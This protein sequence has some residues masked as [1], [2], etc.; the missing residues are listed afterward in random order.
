M[1][2][3][4]TQVLECPTLPSD[5]ATCHALIQ[6]QREQLDNT[7][8]KLSQMEHQLQQLLRRLYGRSAEKID[9]KQMA[10]FAEMLKALE[11]QNQPAEPLPAPAPAAP[12][13]RIGHGRRRL[14]DDLPRERASQRPC[15][16]RPAG[17]RP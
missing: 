12:T 15:D 8:R 5:L 13:N 14:P 4:G 7:T 16:S 1:T 6:V 11:A 2:T 3:D 9:P 17:R 10:L